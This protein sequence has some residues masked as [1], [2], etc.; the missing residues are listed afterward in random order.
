[1]SSV[2]CH[3]VL[4]MLLLKESKTLSDGKGTLPMNLA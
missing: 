2:F 1:M 4:S 3:V